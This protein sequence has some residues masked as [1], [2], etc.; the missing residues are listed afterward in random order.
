MEILIPRRYNG[1]DNSGNGG[2]SAALL[3]RLIDGPASVRLHVPPPLETPMRVE[4][5]D[6]GLVAVHGE[7]IVMEAAPAEIHVEVPAPIS[8]EEAEAAIEGFPGWEFHGASSCFVCG[9]DRET[10]DG[11]RVFPGPVHDDRLVAAPWTPHPSLADDGGHIPDAVVW[12]V[13]DCTGAWAGR[14][15]DREGMPYF[16]ALGSMTASVERPVDPGED[17]VVVA[18]YLGTE[19]RKLF[20]EAVLVGPDGSVRGRATHVTIKV[21]ANWARH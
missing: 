17:L 5:T 14:A 21:P 16:P 19:R 12:G 18:R 11:L 2:Y 10:P 8:R 1:P 6:S 7:Q 15:F 4:E 20:T 13:L 3:G 9:P